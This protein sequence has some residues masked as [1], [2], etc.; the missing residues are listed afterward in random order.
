M[1]NGM[2]CFLIVT[3]VL[4][5]WYCCEGNDVSIF[6]LVRDSRLGTVVGGQ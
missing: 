4:L 1:H 5:L 3:A 6:I 2:V